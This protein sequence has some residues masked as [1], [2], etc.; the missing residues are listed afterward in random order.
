MRDGKQGEWLK[1]E[2]KEKGAFKRK[3]P[4]S[5]RAKL[6]SQLWGSGRL[7]ESWL[8][9]LTFGFLSHYIILIIF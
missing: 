6:D 4:I 3:A 7:C 8:L 2:Q 9:L 5:L 1:T